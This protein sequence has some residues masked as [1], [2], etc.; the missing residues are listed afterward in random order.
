[1]N[2]DRWERKRERWERRWERRRGRLHSPG[3]HLVTG[4]IFVT[5]G[6]IF[7][8]GNM[9]YLDVREFFSFWPV[10]VIAYGV[11]RVVESRDD[12]GHSAGMF[13]I[14]VGLIFLLGSLGILRVAVRE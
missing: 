7:L 5:I 2:P 11:V 12:F 8:L 10:I 4:L 13:W 9:G 6:V 14:A 1:M 3:K